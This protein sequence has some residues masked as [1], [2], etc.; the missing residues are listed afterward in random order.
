MARITN[1]YCVMTIAATFAEWRAVSLATPNKA[2]MQKIETHLALRRKN[3]DGER[4]IVFSDKD[5][6]FSGVL[7]FLPEMDHD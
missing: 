7:A 1:S 6:D 4:T 5:G 3:D 2:F